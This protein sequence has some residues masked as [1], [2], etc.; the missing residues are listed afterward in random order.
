[1]KSGVRVDKAVMSVAITDCAFLSSDGQALVSTGLKRDSIKRAQFVAA[2]C[3]ASESDAR[4]AAVWDMP[5]DFLIL[6][7]SKDE[8]SLRC[9][10]D[11]GMIEPVKVLNSR[12]HLRYAAPGCASTS[13]AVVIIGGEMLSTDSVSMLECF[14]RTLPS[15][16][17]P[18]LKEVARKCKFFVIFELGDALAANDLCTKMVAFSVPE[19]H[20]WVQRCESHQCNLVSSRPMDNHGLCTAMYCL[21]RLLRQKQVHQRLCE[22]MEKMADKEV[23]GQV[24]FGR[25]PDARSQYLFRALVELCILPILKWGD[26]AA[27]HDVLA[28]LCRMRKVIRDNFE[29]VKVLNAMSS[30]TC[31]HYCI[32]DDGTGPCCANVRETRAKFRR[33]IQCISAVL[34]AGSSEPNQGKWFSTTIKLRGV[35]GCLLVS[36]LLSRAWEKRFSKEITAALELAENDDV[37][38]CRDFQAENRIRHRRVRELLNSPQM[39]SLLLGILTSAAP[40]EKMHFYIY[41]QDVARKGLRARRLR[42]RAGARGAGIAGARGTAASAGSAGDGLSHGAA[43]NG[44]VHGAGRDTGVDDAGTSGAVADFSATGPGAI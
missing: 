38:A 19:A 30:P 42:E 6:K 36:K 2:E 31:A 7:R 18:K 20:T 41:C 35:L 43:G 16:A 39:T 9:R 40:M 13:S 32:K 26:E 37:A 4:V 15:S 33:A 44:P 34:M 8:S 23:Q 27:E 5:L 25:Q 11:N 22:A 1:M 10:A 29:D 12:M 24:W 28:R 3:L 14:Q 21:A 17:I